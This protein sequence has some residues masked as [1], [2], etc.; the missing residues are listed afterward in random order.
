MSE[1]PKNPEE[2]QKLI[3]E[4][5]RTKEIL[6]GTANIE[7]KTCV[8]CG[9]PVQITDRDIHM[10]AGQ[11]LSGSAANVEVASC[12]GCGSTTASTSSGVDTKYRWRLGKRMIEFVDGK[13]Y[14]MEERPA[15]DFLTDQ[16]RQRSEEFLERTKD[17]EK[18]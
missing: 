7:V 2:R 6:D 8:Q 14:K 10:D 16:Q 18:T 17:V 15:S 11:Q 13:P 4:R 3:E 12:N 1:R 5:K 9:E